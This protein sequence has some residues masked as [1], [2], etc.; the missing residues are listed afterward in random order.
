[1]QN[2]TRFKEVIIPSSHVRLLNV[3]HH[4]IQIRNS[5]VHSLD[6]IINTSN[7]VQRL[8][9]LT[10]IESLVYSLR[11]ILHDNHFQLNNQFITN[12]EREFG[13]QHTTTAQSNPSQSYVNF[14][15]GSQAPATTTTTS[16]SSTQQCIQ[17]PASPIT[18]ER[19]THKH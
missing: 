7:G 18:L 2:Q 8:E 10:L 5:I 6:D 1:M 12:Y 16:A 14:N 4:E 15:A 17:N 19:R 9:T 3:T 11:R 13:T